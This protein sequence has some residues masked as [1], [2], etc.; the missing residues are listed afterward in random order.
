MILEHAVLTVRPGTQDAFQEAFTTAKSLVASMPG[1]RRLI[2]SRDIDQDSSYLLL[3]EWDSV[4]DHTQ[5]F[6]LSGE[7]QEWRRLLH[8]F[9]E[10]FPTVEHFEPVITA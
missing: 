6:R 10:R 2:L 9:Y 4:E 7:Y 5:G 8:H 1:F 3:V